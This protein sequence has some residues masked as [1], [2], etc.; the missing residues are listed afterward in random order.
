MGEAQAEEWPAYLKESSN[1][2]EHHANNQRD[3]WPFIHFLSPKVVLVEARGLFSDA[4]SRCAAL[5][6]RAYA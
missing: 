2:G 1:G 5:Q 4:E 3:R 6:R